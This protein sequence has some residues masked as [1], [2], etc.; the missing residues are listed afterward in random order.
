MIESYFYQQKY[1][2]DSDSLTKRLK[3]IRANFKRINA[4]NRWTSIVSKDIEETLE[5]GE[6]KYY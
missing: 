3:P 4:I 2:V 6:A 1:T 5:G